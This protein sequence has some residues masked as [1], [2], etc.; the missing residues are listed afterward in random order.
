MIPSTGFLVRAPSPVINAN[1]HDSSCEP[2]DLSKPTI[3][4]EKIEAE[5]VTCVPE[6]HHIKIKE[7]M[8]Y[9]EAMDEDA[10]LGTFFHALKLIYMK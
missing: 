1:D 3:K 7:E 5:A 9:E 2:A 10:E 6:I 4:I 8:D